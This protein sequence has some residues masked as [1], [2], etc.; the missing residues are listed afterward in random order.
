M[1]CVS[2]QMKVRKI[3]MPRPSQPILSTAIITD[4]VMRAV[5]A[6]GDFTMP[7]IA[8]KLSVR[9][10]SLYN[11]VSG[12]AEII[13]Y[14]RARVMAGVSVDGESRARSGA[15]RSPGSPASIGAATPNIPG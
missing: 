9:P 14:M 13:E 2:S 15:R 7:G 8:E 6:A 5:D 4:A 10:S 1:V 3:S 11:H 12:R